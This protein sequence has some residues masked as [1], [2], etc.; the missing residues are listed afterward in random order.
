MEW[1][2]PLRHEALTP[3]FKAFTILGFTEFFFLTLPLLYWCWDKDKANRVAVLTL[4]AGILTLFFKDLF[5][6]PRPPVEVAVAGLR[7]E[8]YGLPSGHTLMAIVFWGA[9]AIETR[10]RW[11]LIVA[12]IMIPGITLSRLYLGVHDLED[13]LGGI[14]IGGLLLTALICWKRCHPN[15][16]CGRLPWLALS[17]FPVILIFLWPHGDA[18]GKMVLVTGFFLSW[19]IGRK[20]EPQFVGFVS[21]A[22]WRKLAVAA[23]GMIILML[24]A[25][26]FRSL[27]FRIGVPQSIA[28]ALGG[29]LIGFASTVLV[30]SFL[31]KLTLLHRSKS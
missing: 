22:G 3:I 20:V 8:S 31:V 25:Y 12:A 5:Q 2:L 29:G 13:I 28:P 15:C 27:I 16:C 26:T 19:M 18:T 1:V 24:L 30:P 7:P 9:L 6:D 10:R 23:S 21:P 14:L 11:V 17:L 4:L